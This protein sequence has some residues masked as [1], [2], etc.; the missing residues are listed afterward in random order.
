M[1]D[2]ICLQPTGPVKLYHCW[3][4]TGSV[5]YMLRETYTIAEIRRKRSFL[6]GITRRAP[7][8]R[9]SF[10]VYLKEYIFHQQKREGRLWYHLNPGKRGRYSV[11]NFKEKG[12][13]KKKKSISWGLYA[14]K[15][16]RR[17]TITSWKDTAAD[18][19]SLVFL[20][21]LPGLPTDTCKTTPRCSPLWEPYLC[22][23]A[24]SVHK[25][26]LLFCRQQMLLFQKL[27]SDTLEWMAGQLHS[28]D[29]LDFLTHLS[30]CL[31]LS[32][33]LILDNSSGSHSIHFWI[34]ISFFLPPINYS[35]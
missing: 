1:E 30:L 3:F 28:S 25:Y 34:I 19:R 14:P 20:M 13:F 26:C 15:R 10:E 17:L 21:A 16:L 32:W 12:H 18:N 4:N 8:K 35:H 6:T 22:S 2:A 29:I 11:L 24:C 5:F 33:G 9:R 31:I 23:Q 27:R 7:W